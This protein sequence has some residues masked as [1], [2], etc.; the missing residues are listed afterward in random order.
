MPL[1][2]PSNGTT[3]PIPS[4][5]V[6]WHLTLGAVLLRLCFLPSL[7]LGF[8]APPPLEPASAPSL[9]LPA[10][11]L[12][13]AMTAKSTG[14]QHSAAAST[15]RGAPALLCYCCFTDTCS[16]PK[17]CC[18]GGCSLPCARVPRTAGS[19]GRLHP[20]AASSGMA[21][22]PPAAPQGVDLLSAAAEQGMPSPTGPAAHSCH[23]PVFDV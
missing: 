21:L 17:S 19:C 15:A 9:L 5:A 22:P 11:S 23:S 2:L 4:L 8:V 20:P 6:L 1:S 12:R 10:P 16:P 3:A 14:R 18:G 7:L 13:A